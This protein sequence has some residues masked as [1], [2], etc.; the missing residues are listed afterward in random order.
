MVI[1]TQGLPPIV[2]NKFEQVQTELQKSPEEFSAQILAKSSQ[3]QSA[4][5]NTKPAE[6]GQNNNKTSRTL[7]YKDL[8]EKIGEL[9]DNQNVAIEFSQDD[10]TKKMIMKVIDNETKEVIKQFPPEI[11]LK[12]ARIVAES[13]QLTNAKV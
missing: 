4:A 2:V 6:K 9:I 10:T 13:G 11:T 3:Q 8:A 1:S 5:D 12:I 7:N